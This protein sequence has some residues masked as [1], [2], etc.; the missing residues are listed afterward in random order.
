MARLRSFLVKECPELVAYANGVGE[1]PLFVAVEE[2]Y[3]EIAREILKVESN[4]LYG[5]RDGANVLHAIIIRT[6]KRKFHD[7]INLNF[8]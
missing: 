4:C 6:L 5:G 3:L 2:D 1:S 8:I 7:I